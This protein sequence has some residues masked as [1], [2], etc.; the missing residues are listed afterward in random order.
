MF[1]SSPNI[2]IVGLIFKIFDSW[3]MISKG[4]LRTPFSYPA[5]VDCAILSFCA[6]CDCESF[7][8]DV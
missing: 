8:F 5:Y 6:I 7:E 2:S 1:A 3:T 4:I